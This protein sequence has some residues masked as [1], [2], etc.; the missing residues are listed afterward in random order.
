[1]N[2]KTATR[3]TNGGVSIKISVKTTRRKR[4]TKRGNQIC[5]GYRQQLVVSVNVVQHSQGDRVFTINF[6]V[7]KCLSFVVTLLTSLCSSCNTQ[8]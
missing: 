2:C 5:N 7:F 4:Y 6:K 1:M 3:A 8:I